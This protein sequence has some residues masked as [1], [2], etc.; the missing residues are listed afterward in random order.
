MRNIKMT[1]MY[2]GSRYYGWQKLGADDQGRTI[3]NILEIML[4]KLL[5][6]KTAVIGSGRT[7]AGVHAY[8]QVAN[9]H[10]N[11]QAQVD[12]LKETLNVSLMQSNESIVITSMEA[13]SS[14]FHS[15]YDASSKLYEY[16]IDTGEK[17][18]VFTRN[19]AASIPETLNL[20]PMRKAASYLIGVH[21]FVGF[22][23]EKPG[24]RNTVRE[25]YE[26][27]IQQKKNMISV[28]IK[29]NGFLYNMVRIITGTLV[30]VGKSTMKPE[31]IL[32]I[33]DQKDRQLA[34]PTMSSNGL[35]LKEVW[36][37]TDE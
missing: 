7:D 31:Q 33:L 16:Q 32:E 17:A 29:G 5:G 19:Y 9:F 10:T 28:G 12:E 27:N 6:E 15:R 34:G 21:D 35:F 8:G 11:S 4:G 14:K 36:Y 22:S 3:Q 26:L 2:D 23:S 1:I 30:E 13:V 20:D 24:K 25:I 37:S 18:C